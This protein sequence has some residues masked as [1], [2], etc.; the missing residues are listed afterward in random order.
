MAR[1]SI[2]G[3]A[4]HG[5]GRALFNRRRDKK[6]SATLSL[7]QPAELT[8]R[9]SG[10]EFFRTE[11][12]YTG[13][14]APIQG[15]QVTRWLLV[16][17]PQIDSGVELFDELCWRLLGDGVPL[18]RATYHVGV[19]HP[20]IRGI[21]VRWL[22][23]RK[24][25]EQYSILHGSDD[26]DEYRLSPIRATIERGTPFRRRL[27]QPAAEFPLLERIRKAG[28]TDYLALPLNRTFRRYPV[29]TWAT[30]RPDGFTDS[31]I[32]ALEDINPALAAIA[33][34]RAERRI[35]SSLLDTYLGP[36][37]GRR[38]LAG[39]ILRAQGE[40]M[41]AVI[42]MTDM[43]NFTGLSDRLPGDA[44]IELLDDY[45]DAI[46]SPIRENKGEILKF[47][48]DG[49]LA[50]FPADD[51]EDFTPSSLRALD[52]ATQ[53]LERLAAI[54]QERRESA[55]SEVRAGIGL[56][57][58][59]VIYG[60]VGSADRLDFTV[61]GPAVNLA[62]RIE[63]LTKRLSRPLL[64]SSAFAEICPRPLVSLG[65]QP[66]RG[67]DQPEEVFGLPD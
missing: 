1:L 55:R 50:I 22:R 16:D 38:I 21:G 30:D 34:T 43:R 36:Q 52:A 57:L 37:A 11:G 18:W 64:T 66:V 59:E 13:L 63:G 19:L 15:G 67:L 51:D 32:A 12:A 14:G 39:Q 2:G 20:Q 47:M 40:R 33:E 49:V 17:G 58:G 42:M 61:I 41:R 23:D 29:V 6:L 48:G 62:S 31:D 5:V 10:E 26:T 4:S 56:H 46:G 7:A 65:F 45:F 25:V 53:G 35:S 8:P 9:T 60:N 3:C 44:V 24:I 54:N 27:D 28:A